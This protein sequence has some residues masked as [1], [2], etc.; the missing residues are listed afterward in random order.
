[1]EWTL[2]QQGFDYC[3]DKRLYDRLVSGPAQSVRGHLQAAADYQERLLRFIENHDEPRAA[4]TFTPEQARAA[5]VVMSTL[6]G[7]PPVSRRP[8]RRA[9]H[10]H[11]GVPRARPRAARRRGAARVLRDAA[12]ARSPTPTCAT[13]SGSCASAAAG[14]TTT[15]PTSWSPGAGAP[16][17]GGTSSS[18]TS[19]ARKRQAR[20]RLPWGDLAGRTWQLRNALDGDDAFER[21]GDELRDEGLYVAM[22]PW[23]PYLLEFTS[24]KGRPDAATA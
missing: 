6:A 14:P 10:A 2:Q 7:R 22:R 12:A 3:Y 23:E 21:D 17:A 8:A 24:T 13:A 1:M 15:A 4:D 20:V 5:A 18:S 19:P 9:P 16:T 11:P